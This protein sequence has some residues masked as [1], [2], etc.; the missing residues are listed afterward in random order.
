M[1]VELWVWI[2]LLA[3]VLVMLAVDLFMH[4]DAHVISVK[5]AAVHKVL[6]TTE[7]LSECERIASGGLTAAIFCASVL[8]YEPSEI[9]MGKLRSGQDSLTIT[10]KPTSKIIEQIQVPHGPK[11]GFK[12]EVGLSEQKAHEIAR[13]YMSRCSLEAIIMNELTTVSSSKHKALGFLKK[14]MDEKPTALNSKTDIA[15]F[16][17]K[18]IDNATKAAHSKF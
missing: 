9:T 13:D 6:T 11:I 15:N 5:E 8:D 3:I 4:R 10:F 1:V 17:T 18:I 14:N 12:L 7:M 2:A 16:I